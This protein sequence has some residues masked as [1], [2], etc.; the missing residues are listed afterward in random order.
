MTTRWGHSEAGRGAPGASS[1]GRFK[2]VLRP[3]RAS[4]LDRL[5]EAI[6]EDV[7][8]LKPWLSW[9][10]EEPSSLET[11]HRRLAR[12]IDEF[13]SGAGYRFAI[14]PRGEP[15]H[16]LGGAN[17]NCRFGPAA[18]DVGC[19]V[20]KSAVRRGVASASLARL[21]VHAFKER[22][23]ERVISQCDVENLAS[24][25]LSESLGFR[26]LERAVGSYPDGSARPL[27]RY[28][29]TAEEYG[30]LAEGLRRSAVAAS[31]GRY[32]S[33]DPG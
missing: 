13:E 24:Q 26:L 20:R 23:V 29:L 18:H 8:H 3:W 16:V 21:T 6:D 14:T 28:V 1:A 2:L 5:R 30:P 4:D 11:T 12:W 31:L 17:L 10:L 7:S 33:P 22:G 15:R 19:W 27:L 25:R 32:W 9:T